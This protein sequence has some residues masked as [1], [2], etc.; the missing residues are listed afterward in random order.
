MTK[1]QRDK[2]RRVM[3][4]TMLKEKPEYVKV[5]DALIEKQ[6]N[7]VADVVAPT[8]KSALEKA[9][10]EG[11]NI[12]WYGFALRAIENIKHMTTVEEIKN[13]FQEEANKTREKFN[14]GEIE[15][16]V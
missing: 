6:P 9:R 4:D 12:G 15:N 7:G 8:I 2:A 1:A 13:Y 5:M 10:M 3:L 16:E 14:L 11:V